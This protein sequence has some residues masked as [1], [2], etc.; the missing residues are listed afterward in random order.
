LG[1]LTLEARRLI[2]RRLRQAERKSGLHL[3]SK[4]E[5]ALIRELWKQDATSDSYRRVEAA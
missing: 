2:L 5:L 3:I 1:P 4:R